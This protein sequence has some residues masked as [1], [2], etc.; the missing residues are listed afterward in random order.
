MCPVGDAALWW[1]RSGGSGAACA[2]KVC[3]TWTCHAGAKRPRARAA[4][5]CTRRP[6]LNPGAGALLRAELGGWWALLAPADARN[7]SCNRSSPASNP[8]SKVPSPFPLRPAH[9]P[10]HSNRPESPPSLGLLQMIPHSIIRGI[11]PSLP[12]TLVTHCICLLQ[13]SPLPRTSPITAHKTRQT[14]HR[15]GKTQRPF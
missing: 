5:A 3:N 10:H 4:G 7:K 9:V 12:N 6:D 14:M 15:W 8:L 13:L 11:S 2:S 1:P